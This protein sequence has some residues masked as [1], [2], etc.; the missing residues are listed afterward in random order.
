MEWEW[1]RNGAGMTQGDLM[2]ILNFSIPGSFLVHSWDSWDFSGI[3]QELVGECKDLISISVLASISVS[4]VSMLDLELKLARGVASMRSSSA[5]A[6]L[7][8][9][10]ARWILATLAC[11]LAS[12]VACLASAAALTSV[13]VQHFAA[14]TM[15]PGCHVAFIEWVLRGECMVL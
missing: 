6:V 8:N 12:L 2:E 3:H 5:I 9:A 14:L 1:T 13:V 7:S 15:R 11:C 4:M 10:A